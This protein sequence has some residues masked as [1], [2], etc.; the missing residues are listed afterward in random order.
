MAAHSE[1]VQKN[2]TM[3]MDTDPP[4]KSRRSKTQNMYETYEHLKKTTHSETGTDK[5]L[6]WLWPPSHK[7]NSEDAEIQ[8]IVQPVNTEK[9]RHIRN[10]YQKRYD[11]Y[12]YRPTKQIQKMQKSKHLWNL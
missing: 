5:Y 9:W 6:R 10:W 2:I 4:N 3:A 1:P 12:G 8:T 7:T 11:C